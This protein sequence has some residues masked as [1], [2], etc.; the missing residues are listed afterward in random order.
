MAPFKKIFF[1]TITFLCLTAAVVR[2]QDAIDFYN[3]GLNSTLSYKK[4]KY[5]TKALQLDPTLVP[6]Y[7]QRAVHYYFQGQ[8]DKAI[9]DYTRIIELK[10][11]PADAYQRRGL[12]CLRKAHGEG[13]M[14]EINRLVHRHRQPGVPEN[15]DFLEKAIDDFSHAVELEPQ[16]AMAYSYRA[17]AHRLIGKI[18]EA[19]LD[20][21]RAI[22]LSENAII[23]AHAY[24]V[25]ALVY[26]QLG[27]NARYEATYSNRVELEPYSPDYP[28]LN[29]PLI[30]KS[31]TPNTETLK[32]VS[33]FGLIGMIVI[34]FTVIFKLRLRAPKKKK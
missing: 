27:E 5:F 17:E 18:D 4:I 29:V 1:L 19:V 34:V 2:G 16:T 3:R 7:E 6:A 25:L 26:R 33:R 13:M 22:Q 8:L 12:A 23:S 15:K 14:A 32:L 24:N 30:L 11:H 20:A 28:P 10:T 9:A 31:Y 21:N